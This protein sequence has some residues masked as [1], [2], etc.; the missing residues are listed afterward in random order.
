VLISEEMRRAA[1][2]VFFA[3]LALTA[4]STAGARTP[5]ERAHIQARA[6]L[7]RA[8]AIF[9]GQGTDPRG[10][11]SALLDLKMQ[12]GSLQP[13][14]R[15]VARSLF[16]RP[17]DG[18]NGD[19]T[20]PR[21]SRH[22]TCAPKFCIHW[23]T[24]SRDAPSLRD[25]NH[26]H[27]PDY[28][29]SVKSV[30]T[31]VWAKEV[32]QLGYH[33]PLADGNSGS[34]HGGNPNNKIDIYLQDVGRFGFYGYCTSDDP[35][36][37]RQ[38]NVSGYCVFDDDFSARQFPATHGVAALK[39]T[40]AHEFNHAIQFSYD[41][42]E[43]RWLLEATA[44]NME[45]T[46]YRTIHD[47]YQYFPSSPLSKSKPWRPIDLFQTSGTNQYGVW[48][49][50]HFLCQRYGSCD[51]VRE[52]WEDAA[53]TPG[54]KHGLLYS[55]QAVEEAISNHGDTFAD[56]FR[57]FGVANQN[58]A[59]GY[60]DGAG[61]G[62]SARLRN[63]ANNPMD[64]GFIYSFGLGMFHMANDY[65][66][67]VPGTGASTVD[68]SFDLPSLTGAQVTVI[69]YDQNGTAQPPQVPSGGGSLNGVSFSTAD[70]SKIV[71][72]FT[73]ANTAFSCNH[74]T[75]FSCHGNPLGDSSSADYTFEASVP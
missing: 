62:S 58:P 52:I 19:W 29:D 28:V 60:S 33:A 65:V 38:S 57:Q 18:R 13:A 16:A 6:A 21:S 75:N 69:R 2:L 12:M 7:D 55:T 68:F 25:R 15:R 59:V 9:R 39:V 22:H 51:I 66:K 50:F 5:Q 45:A 43:D 4:A 61:F 63:Y 71:V 74:G 49:F 20:A 46:V 47:N 70:T 23:V 34:H 3:C 40:A 73:N 27:L 17:T 48:I 54:T 67:L 30:M 10:A 64:A 53:A 8:L 37:S 1:A 26:N 14:E 36:Y 24:T 41:V 35:R 11:T 32:N 44:T 42:R 56:V 31:T 72:A